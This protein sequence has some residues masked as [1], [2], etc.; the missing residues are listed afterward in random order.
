VI[1]DHAAY[2]AMT[3]HMQQAAPREGLGLLAGRRGGFTCDRWVPLDN[4]AEFPRLRYEADPEALVEAWERLEADGGRRPWIVCHSHVTTS[5]APSPTDIRYAVDPTLNHM[6]VSLAGSRPV[7]A[8]WRLD[9]TETA[10]KQARK[11]PFQVVDLGFQ[12]NSP[13]DL[14]RGVSGA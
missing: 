3:E 11:I 9:S 10:T 13:T 14:T 5:A 6:I 4:V 1:I 12:G 7:A 8:L 2:Q